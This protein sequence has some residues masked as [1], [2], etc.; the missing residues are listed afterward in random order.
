M[1]AF[2]NISRLADVATVLA[3]N[4]FADLATRLDLPGWKP[5]GPHLAG[6]KL[7]RRYSVGARLRMVAED[8]GPTFVKLGQL[9][10]LRPDLLPKDVVLEL[11]LLQDRVTPEPLGA[12]LDEVHKSLGRPLAEV[13][14]DFSPEPL[15]SASLAQVHRAR[16]KDDGR[17]VAVKVRRPR[18]LTVVEADL[19]L[20]AALAR[21]LHQRVEYLKPYNLPDLV[22]EI[23]L[24]LRQEM[25]FSLEARHMQNAR[26]QQGPKAQVD[27]P[28]PHLDLCCPSLLTM[29][30]VIGTRLEEAA[31]TTPQKKALARQLAGT[32]LEQVLKHGFFHADPHPGNI[33]VQ[34]GG[35]EPR[36]ALLDWGLVGR[37]TPKMRFL[38]GDLLIAAVE[39]E[40]LD[41]VRALQAMG[42]APAQ[43]DEAALAHDVEELLER[44]HSVPLQQI[45]TSALILDLMDLMRVHHLRVQ[46][47]YALLDK[48]F[49]EM[50]GLA[51]E[52]DPDFDAVEVARPFVG[53]LWL[54][55][56]RPDLVYKMA[57]RH[58]R[59][60]LDLLKDLPGRL[61]RLLG[62]MERGEMSME[63]KH[64]GLVPLTKAIQDSSNRVTMGLIV[65]ALIVGS[66]M[67]ITT[68]VEPKIF[69]LPALGLIGYLFSGIAGLWLVWSIFRS[70]RF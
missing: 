53:S 24:H 66:S 3:K 70:G 42:A 29:D 13:Y 48:A 21:T 49:M 12:I 46:P 50:E 31:L 16:R 59:E 30:L 23:T 28:A 65:A 1:G 41:L 20:L 63:F 64:K 32:I 27:I 47:Q 33:L 43:G 5:G 14:E 8:L 56:W 39:R 11:R 40:P 57:R 60:G 38:V 36:L 15:A 18:I 6:E 55:R 62:L 2:Q 10:S 68:G 37:L 69:G 34:S 67:I 7:A 51:R 45:D 17:W 19:A 25:D 52:L 61:D 44:V 26:A 22:A 54:E 9:V 4:G 58:V 35:L